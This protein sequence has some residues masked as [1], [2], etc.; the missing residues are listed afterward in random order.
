MPEAERPQIENLEVNDEVILRLI[1]MVDYAIDHAKLFK[2]DETDEEER[3]ALYRR[4]LGQEWTESDRQK[5][6]DLTVPKEVVY[7]PDFD[8]LRTVC[9]KHES[10]SQGSLEIVEDMIRHEQAH[11]EKAIEHEMTPMIGLKFVINKKGDELRVLPFISI[12]YSSDTII[13]QQ[14]REQLSDI[15]AAPGSDVS[16]LDRVFIK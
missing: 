15:A 13:T 11:Y 8:T 3:R 4:M 5:L 14:T 7:F 9:Q 10:L 6:K 2:D 16:K 12:T 1:E